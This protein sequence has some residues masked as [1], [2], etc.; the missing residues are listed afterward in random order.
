MENNKG[1]DVDSQR[2]IGMGIAQQREK[3]RGLKKGSETI[4]AELP[5]DELCSSRLGQYAQTLAKDAG[6]TLAYN[7]KCHCYYPRIKNNGDKTQLI[8]GRR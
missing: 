4:V 8:I 5:S 1:Y 2:C 3:L 6:I 7:N